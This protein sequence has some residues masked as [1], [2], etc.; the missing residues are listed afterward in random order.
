MKS[1]AVWFDGQQRQS[2]LHSKVKHPESRRMDCHEIWYVTLQRGL[3]QIVFFSGDSLS[4]FSGGIKIPITLIPTQG[5]KQGMAQ[6]QLYV[7]NPD[8][9]VTS[10]GRKSVSAKPQFYGFWSVFEDIKWD[11]WKHKQRVVDRVVF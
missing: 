9:S 8:G 5:K 7:P 3:N 4:V 2:I 10:R 11:R 6:I 1:A